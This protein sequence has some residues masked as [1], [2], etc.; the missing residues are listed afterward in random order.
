LL[1]AA[2]PQWRSF[3]HDTLEKLT[4]GEV[5]ASQNW[6]G[7]SWRARQQKP[8]LA[9]GYPR[10]GLDGFMDNVVVLANAPNPENAKL[11]QNFVMAP[12]NAALISM[13]TRYGNGIIGSERYMD[14]QFASSPEVKAPAEA[15]A[16]EFVPPCPA[17]VVD[18]YARIWAVLLK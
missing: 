9:F 13:F 5:A 15:P 17:D 11:F 7:P 2:R 4:S 18:Q 12:E 1:I 14:P 8:T 3:G 10:E 6:N 16:P